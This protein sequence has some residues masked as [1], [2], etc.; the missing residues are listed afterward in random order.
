LL[1]YIL[2]SYKRNSHKSQSVV[3]EFKQISSPFTPTAIYDGCLYIKME[4]AEA[5]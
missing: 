2:Q 1:Y 5:K 4:G 3:M